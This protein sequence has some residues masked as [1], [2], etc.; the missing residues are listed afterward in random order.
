M[1]GFVMEFLNYI[2][3]DSTIAELL[4]VQNFTNKESAI[5]EL[6][7]NAYDAHAKKITLSF[8]E[9]M[10]TIKDNGIGMDRNTVIRDWMHVGKSNKGYKISIDNDERILAGSKG[11][12]RFALARLGSSVVIYSSKKNSPP[13]KWETNWNKNIL[14]EWNNPDNIFGTQIEISNLRDKWSEKAISNLVDFLSRTYNDDKMIIEI[15]SP[16]NNYTATRYFNSPEIGKNCV[17]K[18]YLK[19]THTTH[20]L[21]C[22]VNSDEFAQSAEK[23]CSDINLKRYETTI[24]MLNAIEGDKEFDLSKDDFQYL[25]TTLGS[26]ESEFYFSLKSSTSEDAE[27]FCYKYRSLPDRY[28]DGVILYRNAFSISSY[29]GAKD[30]LGFGKRSRLSPAAAS[31][32]T[33]SWRIRENQI[34]GKVTIDKKDNFNLNDMSNRQG[35]EENEYYLLLTKIIREGISSFERYRQSIIR[36]TSEKKTTSSNST[37]TII[38]KI[39]KNPNTAKTLTS[40]DTQVLAKELE[41]IKYESRTYKEEKK[42]TEERYRYDVRILNVLATSGLKATSIAHEL[43]NDRN[44]ISVNYENIVNAL[45]EYDFWDALS[46]PEY[47]EYSYKNVPNLLKNNKE[48]SKKILIFMDTMLDEVEKHKFTVKELNVS[49][50]LH[51]IK[52]NWERDYASLEITLDI[53]DDL[54]FELSDDIFTVIFDNLILNSLQQNEKYSK[55]NV[56]ISIKKIESH[57]DVSYFD[58]GVGLSPKYINTPLRIL[59]VHETSRVN[60]HG[61]GMWIVNNTVLMTGGC[62]E[63]IEGHN[64]FKID[65]E[66]GDKI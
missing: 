30:W 23:R 28:E 4:G 9:D 3:E 8:K 37:P 53:N 15:H 66:L 60:G 59:E 29:D 35:L 63:N 31:H 36:K 41:T 48:I 24:N 22:V 49:Q 18:I 44:S 39:I 7:K 14:D 52:A 46:S 50:S 26:F 57:L 61:L 65:F 17:S 21:K 43:K 34:S 54:S 56:T 5:L 1:E 16:M 2:V 58:N 62:I 32:P 47:M 38:N 55:I 33:G 12:G 27:K 25:L 40:K 64:G 20:E 45:T 51:L 11:I 6:V 19:Y 10:L 13:L 42:T